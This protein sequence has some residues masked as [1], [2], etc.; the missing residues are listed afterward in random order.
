MFNE[1]FVDWIV[2][3]GRMMGSCAIA[4]AKALQWRIAIQLL[5]NVEARKHSTKGLEGRGL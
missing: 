1:E 5:V 2:Q 3:A 4:S